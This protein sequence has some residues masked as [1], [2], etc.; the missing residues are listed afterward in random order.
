VISKENL[1]QSSKLQ[2]QLTQHDPK[3]LWNDAIGAISIIGAGINASHNK[4]RA[5][6]QALEQAGIRYYGLATSSFRVTWL[7]DREKV[8][9][10]V[11]SLHGL[12]I[13]AKEPVVPLE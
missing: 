10:A 11:R 3:A 6:S 2:A 5:G 4:V 8:E 13:E 9:E 1:H 7:V 12:F